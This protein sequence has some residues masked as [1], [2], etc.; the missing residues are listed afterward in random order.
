ME[1]RQAIWI[2]ILIGCSTEKIGI[3]ETFRSVYVIFVMDQLPYAQ[4]HLRLMIKIFK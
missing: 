4:R 1:R 2:S 3:A